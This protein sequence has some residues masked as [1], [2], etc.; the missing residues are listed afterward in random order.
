MTKITIPDEVWVYF[1]VEDGMTIWSLDEDDLR[2]W[3]RRGY[4]TARRRY[5]SSDREV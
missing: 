2:T 3:R 1:A 4:K 5:T